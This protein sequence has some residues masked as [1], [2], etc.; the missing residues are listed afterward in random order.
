MPISHLKELSIHYQES[1]EGQALVIL[2]G[3]GN[4]SQ[5]W[6]HQLSELKEQYRVIVW[7]APGYGGSSDL[8]KEFR[9]FSEF[10]NVLKEF[11]DSLGLESIYLLGHSMGSA[12]AIDFTNRFPHMVDA[13]I[14][15]DATRGAA[16]LSR[17]ENEKKLQNRLNSIENLHPTELA[18]KRVKALLAP[19]ASAEVIKEAERIMSQVRLSGYRSVSYSLSSLNQMEILSS[20]SAPTL[21]MCGELDQV[22]PVSESQIFHELI[23]NSEFVIVPNTGH[24]CYQEDPKLFNQSV[25]NFLKKQ[26]IGQ[27]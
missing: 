3:L 14:I 23:P 8:Q 10:A 12:I 5:S 16:G 21:V 22:T 7:D 1:G 19:N 2:H 25:L 20:I 9:E 15:S 6:K 18:R 11:L 24:L 4:N 17:E 27:N 26:P 13:L